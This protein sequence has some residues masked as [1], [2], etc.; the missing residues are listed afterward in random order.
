MLVTYGS[1]GNLSLLLFLFN[2]ALCYRNLKIFILGLGVHRQI[3]W[4]FQLF[5]IVSHQTSSKWP[6]MANFATE[7]AWI[8]SKWAILV[9]FQQKLKYLS[10]ISTNL[11]RTFRTGLVFWA[12]QNE[13]KECYA[14]IK[15]DEDLNISVESWPI[16]TKSSEQGLFYWAD[17][18]E[19]ME[20]YAMIKTDRNL[21]ISAESQLVCTSN[22]F[23]FFNF[24]ELF[25]T[26]VA[27]NDPQWQILP[28][29]WL[30]LAQNSQFRSFCM[31]FHLFP[32]NE[33][34]IDSEWSISANSQLFPSFATK[35]SHFCRNLKNFHSKGGYIGKFFEFFNFFES[36]QTEAAQNDPQWQIL[37]KKWLRI[38]SKWPI[39]F[40]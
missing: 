1:Q 38:G 35:A 17:W 3:F 14:T 6:T 28:K 7:V 19:S 21:N 36:L 24:F 10:G 16:C 34:Q 37:P 30:R 22:F 13:S 2:V 26:K 25:H 11:H 39:L 9:K 40:I 27:Q 18:Y 15:T 31:C 32:Q 5:Q 29:M 20:W 33:A 12:G 4:V 23:E 8:S